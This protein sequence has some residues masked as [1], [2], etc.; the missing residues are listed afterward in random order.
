[1]NPIIRVCIDTSRVVSVLRSRWTPLVV[2]CVECRRYA[3]RWLCDNCEEV[4]CV[5]CYASVHMH[6]AKVSFRTMQ[7]SA[8]GAKHRYHRTCLRHPCRRAYRKQPISGVDLSSRSRGNVGDAYCN[9]CRPFHLFSKLALLADSSGLVYHTLSVFANRKW[10]SIQQLGMAQHNPP[11]PPQ[12]PCC[13]PQIFM[14]QIPA[15]HNASFGNVLPSPDWRGSWVS[16]YVASDGRPH[17]SRI[18]L[19]VCRTRPLQVNHGAEKLPYYPI[20]FHMEYA[21]ACRRRSRK[22]RDE[23]AHAVW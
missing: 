14:R 22:Q 20:D 6:G 1:M 3:A 11:D 7:S 8:V 5:G 17:S 23:E 2:I 12:Q 9:T 4:Y 19:C 13:S 18:Y 21:M 15:T 10:E 16:Q